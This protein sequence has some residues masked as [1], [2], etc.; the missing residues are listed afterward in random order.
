MPRTKKRDRGWRDW[1]QLERWRKRAKHQ[2]LIEPLCCIC[3]QNGRNVPAR[4]ADHIVHHRGDWNEFRLGALQSL[5][6]SCHNTIKRSIDNNGFG[7]DR[8]VGLD[9]LPLDVEHHPI[10][11]TAQYQNNH[12]APKSAAPWLDD[13]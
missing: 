12:P 1:Y 10:F 7:F 5:C 8:H 6:L 13:R 9:G 11:K 4:I 3:K 2:L